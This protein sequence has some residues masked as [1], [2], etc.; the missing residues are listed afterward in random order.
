[1]KFV[2][3]LAIRCSNTPFFVWNL[4]VV[5]CLTHEVIETFSVHDEVA[6]LHFNTGSC[7]SGECLKAAS[8][9]V[10]PTFGEKMRQSGNDIRVGGWRR[11]IGHLAGYSLTIP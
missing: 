3:D 11:I 4:V 7:I 2:E 9:Y 10:Q 5:I 8:V 6:L 1:M